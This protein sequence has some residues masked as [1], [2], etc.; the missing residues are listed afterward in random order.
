MVNTG[1]TRLELTDENFGRDSP[2][3]ILSARRQSR[4]PIYTKKMYMELPCQKVYQLK[5]K[6]FPLFSADLKNWLLFF[7]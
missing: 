6:S 2:D 3:T 1:T 4:N 5:V 7:I